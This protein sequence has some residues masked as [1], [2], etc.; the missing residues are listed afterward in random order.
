MLVEFYQQGVD[1]LFQYGTVLGQSNRIRIDT[2]DGQQVF[3]HAVQ[4][5]GIRADIPK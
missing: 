3:H 2:G 4:P 5:L 1:Q